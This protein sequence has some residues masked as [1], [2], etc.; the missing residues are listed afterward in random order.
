[1]PDQTAKLFAFAVIAQNATEA[2]GRGCELKF[3]AL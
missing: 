2:A 3:M 1:M